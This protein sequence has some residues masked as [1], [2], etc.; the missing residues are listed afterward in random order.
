[1]SALYFAAVFHHGPRKPN[2]R[3]VLMAMAEAADHDSGEVHMKAETIARRA[4]VSKSTAWRCIM[5]L[6]ASNWIVEHSEG[7]RR[8]G[9]QGASHFVLSIEKLRGISGAKAAPAAALQVSQDDTPGVSGCD[10]RC[11]NVTHHGVSQ[12]DTPHITLS[13]NHEIVSGL[14]EFQRSQIRRGASTLVGSA[15]VKPGTAH[16]TALQSALRSSDALPRAEKVGAA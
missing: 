11:L 7:R 13:L 2:E 10:T 8:N 1:M 3:L 4:G 12:D 14:S 6:K 16:M 15:I 5:A 9:A